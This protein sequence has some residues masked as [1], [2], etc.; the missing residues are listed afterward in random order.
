MKYRLPNPWVM[1]PV[2]AAFLI[3][4][5]VGWS[6][7]TVGCRPEGCPVTAALVGTLAAFVTAAGVLIVAVLAVRSL[8][9]WQETNRREAGSGQVGNGAAEE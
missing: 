8:G 1:V 3:G 5:V 6:V 2:L 4:G 7:M 9:E